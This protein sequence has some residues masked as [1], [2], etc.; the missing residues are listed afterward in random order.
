MVTSAVS[1]LIVSRLLSSSLPSGVVEDD[2]AGAGLAGGD[3]R[4]KTDRNDAFVDPPDVGF[5]GPRS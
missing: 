1:A 5:R 4:V 2:L 3:R